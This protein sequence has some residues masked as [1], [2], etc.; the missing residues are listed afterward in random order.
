VEQIASLKEEYRETVQFI[1]FDTL[2]LR[3]ENS[4]LHGPRRREL[5]REENEKEK[6]KVVDQNK[7]LRK[8]ANLLKE[9]SVLKE[10]ICDEARRLLDGGMDMEKIL[11]SFEKEINS[12]E[13]GKT[14]KWNKI[15]YSF[16]K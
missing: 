15:E 11:S 1:P 9:R 13:N 14:K 5:R 4:H 12:G 6:L 7:T 8:N 3:L 16:M 10:I 2:L